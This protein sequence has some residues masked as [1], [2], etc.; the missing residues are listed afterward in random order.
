MIA[1]SPHRCRESF[2][3]DG[4]DRFVGSLSE[5]SDEDVL[6]RVAISLRKEAR[7]VYADRL[8][9]IADRIAGLRQLVKDT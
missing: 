9:A 1:D 6:R 5:L 8:D 4:P 2:A 3:P 7:I